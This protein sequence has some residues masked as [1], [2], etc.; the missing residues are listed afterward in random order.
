VKPSLFVPHSKGLVRKYW[1]HL[2][3]SGVDGKAYPF[4]EC[5]E[6][7]CR[8]GPER[9]VWIFCMLA[10]MPLPAKAI[11]YF[12][13]QLLAFIEAHGDHAHYVLKPVVILP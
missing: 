10:S 11:L 5:W 12:H 7:F 9:W 13:D 8:G 3:Q 6:G 1:E 2:V 4:E